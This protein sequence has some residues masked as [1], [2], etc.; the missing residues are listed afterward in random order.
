MEKLIIEKIDGKWSVN[1]KFFN[2]LSPNEKNALVS[3]IKEY[4]FSEMAIDD[5][6]LSKEFQGFM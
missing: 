2:E 4:D 3:F 1:G 5:I 6:R